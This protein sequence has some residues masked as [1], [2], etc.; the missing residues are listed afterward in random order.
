MTEFAAGAEHEHDCYINGVQYGPTDGT[1]TIVLWRCKT[2]PAVRSE[3]LAG[4]W[5]ERQ[6]T[7]R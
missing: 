4:R 7:G 1:T 5:T 3:Q 2:C 6:L